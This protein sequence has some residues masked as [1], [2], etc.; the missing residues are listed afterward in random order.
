MWSW[1]RH[2]SRMRGGLIAALDVGSSKVCCA[3]AQVQGKHNFEILGV[4][5]QLSGGVKSGV[6][7]NMEEVVT[8]IVNA[9]HTAE[10][11]AGVTIRDVIVSVNGPHLKSVNFTVEMNVSGHPIDDTDIR[12]ILLQAKAAREDPSLQVFIRFLQ[13][14]LLMELKV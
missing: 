1:G 14:M 2:H 6:V 4:G 7:I 5:Q 11:M 12:R 3:I 13:G 8:S 9:V 10:K